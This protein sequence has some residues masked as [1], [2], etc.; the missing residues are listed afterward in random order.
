MQCR[1]A[2]GERFPQLPPQQLQRLS[3]GWFG[4]ERLDG[5]NPYAWPGLPCPEYSRFGPTAQ[6]LLVAIGNERLMAPENGMGASAPDSSFPGAD[7]EN[8]SGHFLKNIG[9]RAV[10]IH[11]LLPKEE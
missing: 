3:N 6:K 10:G 4:L 1:Q 2:Q 7:I 11:H 8:I 5:S 9:L